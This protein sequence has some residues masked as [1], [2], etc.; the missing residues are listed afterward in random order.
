LEVDGEHVYFVSEA[1]ILVHNAKRYAE[2]LE[3][4]GS[5]AEALRAA[6]TQALHPQG[7]VKR[8]ALPGAVDP[9]KLGKRKS[10][11]HRMLIEAEEGTIAWLRQ[12]NLPHQIPGHNPNRVFA[13]PRKLIGELNR[14]IRR[15]DI[16]EL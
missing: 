1:G 4:F 16:E 11:S 9:R 7:P 13:I 10:Y 14:R 12:H 6:A 8:L 15:I 3:R 2:A 5:K